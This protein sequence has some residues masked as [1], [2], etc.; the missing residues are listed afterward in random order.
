MSI[1]GSWDLSRWALSFRGEKR[2]FQ[3]H[4]WLIDCLI[5]HTLRSIGD[6][7]HLV[8]LYSLDCVKLG[9]HL[10][11]CFL[12]MRSSW[13]N[14]APNSNGIT[15]RTRLYRIRFCGLICKAHVA[16]NAQIGFYSHWRLPTNPMKSL[17]PRSWSFRS[18]CKALATVEICKIR[19]SATRAACKGKFGLSVIR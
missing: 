6:R 13:I 5:A 3:T 1:P 17:W 2:E 11:P 19:T 4:L 15:L 8:L 9:L 14:R 18:L 10:T 12:H 16:I 7:F